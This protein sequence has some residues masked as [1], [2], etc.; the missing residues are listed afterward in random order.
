MMQLRLLL[1]LGAM[2]AF[3]ITAGTAGAVP[4][5]PPALGVC[6]ADAGQPLSGTQNGNLRITGNAYVPP[7]SSFTL[8]GNMTIAPGACFDAVSPTLP[9]V[10]NGNVSVGKGG[11]F[12]IGFFFG[13]GDVVNGSINA[14]NALTLYIDWT[15]VH[16]N[17]VSN[18]GGD[19][20]MVD[21]A[22]GADD[23][24]VLPIKDNVVDGNVI[25]QG[26]AGAWAGLIRTQVGGNVIWSK[27]AGARIG[28]SG[29]LD[30]NEIATNTITGN[31]I[32][33]GNTPA[34]QLG[35]SGGSLNVVG[36]NALGECAGLKS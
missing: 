14:S 12:G 24:L 7:G 5:P 13:T 33:N 20:T 32:C 11:V 27:N 9:V 18:G 31:L 29:D 19:A 21:S 10:I 26:W 23:G 28:D 2:L 34:A 36:G 8:N 17:I 4:P 15:A 16:G 3:G 30:S 25:V 22:P 1:G 35:D 6:G